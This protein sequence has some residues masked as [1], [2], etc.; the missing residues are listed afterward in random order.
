[1]SRLVSSLLFAAV[2]FTGSEALAWPTTTISGTG[3][4]SSPMQSGY[5]WKDQGGGAWTKWNSVVYRDQAI[6]DLKIARRSATNIGP[7]WGAWSVETI[8]NGAYDVGSVSLAMDGNGVEY[9]S[10]VDTTSKNLK[11][12]KRV[13]GG[14]GN[15][16]SGSDWDCATLVFGTVG[17]TAIGV[18]FDEQTQQNT[19]HIVYTRVDQGVVDLWHARKI[20]SGSWSTAWIRETNAIWL[21]PEALGFYGTTPRVA[22]G[23]AGVG[24][25]YTRYQ[26]PNQGD[27]VTS[28]I[29]ASGGSY[30][31][32]V[33]KGLGQ[34][35]AYLS[36]SDLKFASWN[37]LFGTWALSTIDT[38]ASYQSLAV[39]DD[40]VPHI[41]YKKS[42]VPMRAKRPSTTWVIDTADSTFNTGYM[43][44]IEIDS[45]P[46]T[47]TAIVTHT[48]GFGTIRVSAE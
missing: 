34:Y 3:T 43:T 30:A 24:L 20:G 18:S 39:D 4:A 36:G 23:E 2:L 11:F 10:Y 9:V 40:F 26:G 25:R 46:A 21:G 48:N 42:N 27:W 6:N 17:Q 35:I 22:Y 19:I 37:F 32:L 12:A 7:T 41:G 13:G 5:A 16:F 15:C 45:Q 47:D 8:D 14:A 38:S 31:S 44:S 1:M 29:D 33:G 28:T